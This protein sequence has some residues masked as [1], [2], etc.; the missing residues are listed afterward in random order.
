MQSLKI[1]GAAAVFAVM[2]KVGDQ[3]RKDDTFGPKASSPLIQVVVG[4][5]AA[6]D[7]TVRCRPRRPR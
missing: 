3:M 7:V 4:P 1:F 5:A 6:T 2:R